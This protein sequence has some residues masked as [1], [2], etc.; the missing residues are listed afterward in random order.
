V[1]PDG[2]VAAEVN[3]VLIFMLGDYRGAEAFKA[4]L[5]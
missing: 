2:Q 4:L 1:L 3:E 5:D